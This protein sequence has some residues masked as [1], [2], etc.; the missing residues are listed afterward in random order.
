[1]LSV[2]RGSHSSFRFWPGSARRRSISVADKGE[3]VGL[4]SPSLRDR[5]AVVPSEM[6]SS[7]V[8]LTAKS[9]FSLIHVG[10]LIGTGHGTVV[11]VTSL[12]RRDD[13]TSEGRIG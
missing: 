9:S 7:S 2:V 5:S 12:R 10:C 13:Y 6:L 4:N 1:M 3:L 8:L 11:T